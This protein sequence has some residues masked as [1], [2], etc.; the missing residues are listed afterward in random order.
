VN[1]T[2]AA[3]TRILD[4]FTP[5][6]SLTNNLEALKAISGGGPETAVEY[7]HVLDWLTPFE[8]RVGHSFSWS[9]SEIERFV[10]GVEWLEQRPPLT[11]H[12][13]PHK[14]ICEF[15]KQ[16]APHERPHRYR[17]D[18]GPHNRMMIDGGGVNLF[19][20]PHDWA[21]PDL[22]K[23]LLEV[24]RAT[25]NPH[26]GN[27]LLHI[28]LAAIHPFK[29]GNSRLRLLLVLGRNRAAAHPAI[30]PHIVEAALHSFAE[31]YGARSQSGHSSPRG[32]EGQLLAAL[33]ARWGSGKLAR[34]DPGQD[35]TSWVEWFV[36]SE[37][38][39]HVAAGLRAGSSC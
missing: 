18:G 36:G 14:L 9:E 38:R 33:G 26:V 2:T 29:G 4:T 3:G 22:M 28:N 5:T 23:R 15:H 32:Y 27:A 34:W 21:V 11:D 7:R 1:A 30:R 37:L 12:P 10:S 19:V 24:V 16:T 17:R 8:R 35:I 31:I 6:A 20:C 39:L 13:S 25:E